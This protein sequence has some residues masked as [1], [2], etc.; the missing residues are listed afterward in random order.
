MDRR[1]R[2]DGGTGRGRPRA[3]SGGA[4]AAA[5]RAVHR[6]VAALLLPVRTAVSGPAT[7]APA[8]Q[9]GP[10]G[11]ATLGPGVA[12][13]ALPTARRD[14]AGRRKGSPD[15]DRGRLQPGRRGPRA[16][17]PADTATARG[18]DTQ[19][20]RGADPALAGQPRFLR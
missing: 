8:A 19:P 10:A 1:R 9:R 16:D 20:H 4:R 18:P 17:R 11:P 5:T 7:A 14:R 3:A 2:S 15:D 13:P 12:A 6:T